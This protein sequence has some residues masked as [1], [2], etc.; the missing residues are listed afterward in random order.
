MALDET[1]R[2]SASRWATEITNR[3]KANLGNKSKLIEVHS[4][5][6]V[7]NGKIVI[8]AT[9]ENKTSNQWGVVRVARAY[10]YGSG[11][12][13]KEKEP[14]IIKPRFEKVL[15]FEWDVL[16]SIMNETG[17]EGV[18]NA[19]QN[20]GK[21]VGMGDVGETGRPRWLFRYVD[22]PGVEAVRGGQGYMKPAITAVRRQIRKEVPN[23]VRKEVIGNF[24]RA[25]GKNA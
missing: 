25:F 16:D 5:T 7:E 2:Q 9:A 22:H 3:A 13:G 11:E 4:K 20:T 23:D 6:T 18:Q 24:R 15:A 14:Y 10:E 12:H 17:F 1:L 21:F 19:M 8:T